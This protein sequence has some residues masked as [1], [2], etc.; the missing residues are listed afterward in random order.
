MLSADYLS[1]ENKADLHRSR[2]LESKNNESGVDKSKWRSKYN[3]Q[4]T[5]HIASK[6]DD[7]DPSSSENISKTRNE[8]G[9]YHESN[10]V[11]RPN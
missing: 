3:Q 11:A 10:K 7:D 1:D 4:H 2:R 9:A 5:K 8:Q 6:S